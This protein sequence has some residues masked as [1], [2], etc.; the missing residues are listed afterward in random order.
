MAL[1]IYH[2]ARRGFPLSTLGMPSTVILR[3]QGTDSARV[4]HLASG[5]PPAAVAACWAAAAAGA[6]GADE[7]A[8]GAAADAVEAAVDPAAGMLLMPMVM[9]VMLAMPVLDLVLLQP[10]HCLRVR[11]LRLLL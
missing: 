3:K 10:P 4:S 7:A 1:R 8:V 9:L 2:I 11:L 6:A 5:D